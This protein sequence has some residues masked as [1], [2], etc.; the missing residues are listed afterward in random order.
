[1]S[2]QEAETV[3]VLEILL[4]TGTQVDTILYE[5]TAGYVVYL[6]LVQRS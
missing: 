6:L 3:N 1:M 2:L 5:C 4:D